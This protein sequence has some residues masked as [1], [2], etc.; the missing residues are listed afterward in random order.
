MKQSR[1]KQINFVNSK[2]FRE[3]ISVNLKRHLDAYISNF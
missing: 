3:A 2:P 1:E